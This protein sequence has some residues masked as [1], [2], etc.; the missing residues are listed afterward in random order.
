MRWCLVEAVQL[1]EQFI[2]VNTGENVTLSCKVEKSD[3]HVK[4]WYKQQLWQKPKEVVSKLDQKPPFILNAS[5]ISLSIERVAKEDEGMYFCGSAGSNTLNFSTATFLAVTGNRSD[6]LFPAFIVLNTR[7]LCSARSSLSSEQQI[8]EC[9]GSELL[10]DN[11]FLKSF[12]LIRPA[13]AVSVRSALLQAPLC[14]SSL[15]TSL[16]STI[17]ELTTALWLLVGRSSLAME[18]LLN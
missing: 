11:P 14:M 17:L 3:T 18:Q 16:T 2:S 5:G 8:S 7:S 13:A 1:N 10:Q 12:T 9:C 4:V 6:F 15:R